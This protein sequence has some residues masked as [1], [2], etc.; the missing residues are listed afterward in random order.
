MAL[1]FLWIF[2]SSN[3]PNT[4]KWTTS[5]RLFCHYKSLCPSTLT[6]HVHIIAI[7]LSRLIST[8]TLLSEIYDAQ[9]NATSTILF[10]EIY[11]VMLISC[12]FNTNKLQITLSCTFIELVKYHS[13]LFDCTVHVFFSNASS[14]DSMLV[15]P[16][17]FPKISL[18]RYKKHPKIF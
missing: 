8:P 6:L 10:S 17:I 9:L 15:K 7:D 13:V 14:W 1:S 16:D 18:Y 2:C 12:S 11:G 3:N 4:I 5:L